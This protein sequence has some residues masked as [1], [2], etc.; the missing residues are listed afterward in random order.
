LAKARSTRGYWM[1]MQR[2]KVAGG[3]GKV[4]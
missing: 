4:A 2:I 1:K 3:T